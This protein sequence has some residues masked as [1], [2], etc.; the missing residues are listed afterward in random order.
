ME[1]LEVII[2][3]M[4]LLA[5]L[6]AL[7]QRLKL[8]YAVL[9]VVAGLALGLIPGLPAV[10]LEPELVFFIFLPPLLYEASFNMSWHDFKAYK[11]QISL[12]AIGLVFFTTTVIATIAHFFIP[13]FS[14]Q[15]GFV[16][17]AI[18]S[19][20]D[21]V[22]ATS[23]TQGLNLPKKITAIL[24]GE[25]LV[26]DASAL[27]A[28]RY[29]VAAV[30]SGAF[31]FWDAG[32]HFLLVAGGGVVIGL[33]LGYILAWL[34]QR[35]TDATI[36]TTITL[37][38]PFMAY[39]LAEYVG[40]SG[41]LAVVFT[42]IVVA[43]RS[44]EIYDT[45]ARLQKNNFWGVFIFLLNGFVFI[46]IG[47]QLP[48]ILKGVYEHNHTL[49][50]VIGYGLLISAVAIIIRICWIFPLSYLSWLWDKFQ[51]SKRPRESRE[52]KGLF[53]TS[54]A[55]MRGVVSLATALGLPLALRSGAPFPQRDVI[56]FI[57]FTVILVTLVV[58]GLSL[59]WFVRH[60]DLTEPEEKAATEEQKLRLDITTNALQFVDE[61]LAR[62]EAKGAL[63]ELKQRLQSQVNRLNGVLSD[64]ESEDESDQIQ[65]Q[66]F[67]EKRLEV[68][69]HQRNRIIAIHKDGSYAEET[70]RRIE[71]E[72]DALEL[73]LE[74][75]L[76]TISK[77]M[78]E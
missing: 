62:G 45:R 17:G 57:T 7:A 54:W 75:Q 20:P 55:G 52:L 53:I 13:G 11:H 4:A 66:R 46:L 36:A 51:G 8:P 73:N 22:A 34:Q 70:V 30:V 69:E 25:S 71:E 23:A 38:G 19:P 43:W 32:W 24:E 74:T 77:S 41:V 47:L 68:I 37:L 76:N 3:L 42:G 15:L 33:V 27:I 28:Y 21:A 9:L 12:L 39:S 16:L 58:Q 10:V 50:S 48:T 44:Y 61:Q 72:L 59:P 29:A 26:N 49:S 67:L 5:G 6:S 64:M 2:L 65:F 56:L 78:Q 31:S 35:I 18:V 40:A 1:N 14:W 63:E 60:F